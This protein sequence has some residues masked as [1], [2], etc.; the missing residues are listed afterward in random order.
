MTE[1][2][3]DADGHFDFGEF[4]ELNSL[5]RCTVTLSKS[6]HGSKDRAFRLSLR[7]ITK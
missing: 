5:H 4:P 1:L 7:L 3:T 2:R 6:G